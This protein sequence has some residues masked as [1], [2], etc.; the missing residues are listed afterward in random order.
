MEAIALRASARKI[1]GKGPARRA[2]A[3]GLIPAVFY[4][5][6]AETLMLTV[7][8]AD[9]KAFFKQSDENA[10]I[11]LRIEDEG[12]FQER[13]SIVKD[14]QKD[15]LTG[16]ILHV[17]FY[18]I[19]MDHKLTAA[20]SLQFLGTP[21]GVAVGGELQIPKREV[22]LSCLPSVLP[23]HIAVDISG[24]KVG[25]ALRVRDLPAMAGISILEADD[26]ILA[27]VSVTREA[28]KAEAG[29]EETP[30]EPEILKQKVKE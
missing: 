2:R 27:M 11:N 28:M 13:M 25:E 5:P 3:Q 19:S 15:P 9:M 4:N 23:E 21:V 24:L 16:K 14:L 29:E 6:K 1:S 30:R 12:K 18:E 8:D 22:S 17:D 7:S 26:T 20:V 10:F